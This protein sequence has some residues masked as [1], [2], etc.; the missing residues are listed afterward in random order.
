MN[1]ET[2]NN[3]FFVL[4]FLS[5]ILFLPSCH[6]TISDDDKALH[7][8]DFLKN[9]TVYVQNN[10]NTSG[11]ETYSSGSGYIPVWCNIRPNYKNLIRSFNSSIKKTELDKKINL[12]CYSGEHP[13][14]FEQSDDFLDKQNGE[15]SRYHKG[16]ILVEQ[17]FYPYQ[18]IYILSLLTSIDT[19]CLIKE[20]FSFYKTFCLD[21][22][23]QCCISPVEDK[24][25]INVLVPNLAYKEVQVLLLKLNDYLRKTRFNS[26]ETEALF[27]LFNS[28]F[29]DNCSKQRWYYDAFYSGIINPEKFF[30]RANWDLEYCGV[31]T[32][33]ID[34]IGFKIL[35]INKLNS[36]QINNIVLDLKK[37]LK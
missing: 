3:I 30:Y 32:L 28:I 18:K 17:Y 4:V 16:K 12:V 9:R 36:E 29:I 5:V 19:Q 27:S 14:Y 21:S 23:L 25:V 10:P 6:Y 37:F 15:D 35:N 26:N 2:P 20:F 31:E 34:K 33:K 24:F 22:E 8:Q 13:K 11:Y 1:K 7:P